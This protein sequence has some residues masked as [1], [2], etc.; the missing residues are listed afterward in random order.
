MEMTRSVQQVCCEL[1][2]EVK[3]LKVKLEGPVA[4]Q[5]LRA[6]DAPDEIA[7]CHGRIQRLLERLTLNATVNILK[8]LN[9]QD[10]KIDKQDM[11]R[12]L[13]AM[14]PAI[15]SEY[16]S[17]ASDEVRRGECT[18]GTRELQIKSLLI[19]ARTPKAGKIYWMNGMAGTGKT[20][21]AYSICTELDVTS[22]PTKP[23]NLTASP[24]ITTYP[25]SGQVSSVPETY[26]NILESDSDVSTRA[27]K[28]QYQK[29]I[30]EPLTM[31]NDTLPTDFI[32]VIDA[33]DE[34]ENLNSLGEILDLL[35]STPTILPIRFLISSRPEP[36]ISRRMEGQ[37]NEQ[38]DTQLVLHNIDADMVKSDIEVFMRREL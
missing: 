3:H 23:P 16:N 22:K 2:L 27:L 25:C 8:A 30:V 19:W 24:C 26:R 14:S 20:T 35:L 18:P 37:V 10:E 12:R 34:C 36:E 29:L 21:I 15:Y 9:R 28:I 13:N 6:V 5:W 32:V 4:K 31:V 33:L 17:A 1:D 7:E 11:E 38:G